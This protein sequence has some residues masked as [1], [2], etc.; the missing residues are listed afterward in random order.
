VIDTVRDLLGPSPLSRL[1]GRGAW[2]PTAVRAGVAVFLVP[3]GVGKLVDHASE[4][5]DF[6]RYEV[7]WPEVAVPAVGTLEVVGAVLV[8]VGLLTRPAALALALNMVGALATAG[9]VDGGSF[10]LVAAPAVLLASAF[11]VWSGPG[12]WSLDERRTARAAPT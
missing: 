10:H 1:P 2:V 3:I 8:L 5:H 12:R 6:R 7:P 4:V 9:R 11:L